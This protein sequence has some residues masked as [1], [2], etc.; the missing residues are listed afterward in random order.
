MIR[1]SQPDT[2]LNGSKLHLNERSTEILS[3]TF[4][5]SISNIVHWQSILHSPDR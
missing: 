2:Y 1:Q 3:N 4:L 5:E